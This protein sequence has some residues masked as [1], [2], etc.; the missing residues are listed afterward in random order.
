MI[1]GM[2]PKDVQ[3]AMKKLGIKQEEIDASEVI[4]KTNDKEIIIQN[5]QVSKVN[6][7]GQDTYQVVG[8]AEERAVS[9]EPE[10]NEDD[11]KTVVQQ[12]GVAEEKAR[13][14][15]AR[16]GGDLAKTIME[17]KEQQ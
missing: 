6:M 13:E 8:E 7:M 16:N 12:A 17:L 1:P 10:I 2:N 11:V 3:R 15:I 9:S 5:P 14:A 4:I